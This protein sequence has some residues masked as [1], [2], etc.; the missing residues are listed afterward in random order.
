MQALHPEL[1]AQQLL[2]LVGM[3]LG[4]LQQQ[5][6]QQQQEQ[7]PQRHQGTS[8][9]DDSEEEAAAAYADGMAAAGQLPAAGDA[10][11]QGGGAAVPGAAGTPAGA[12]QGGPQAHQAV[13]EGDWEDGQA[14]AVPLSAIMPPRAQ[15]AAEPSPIVLEGAAGVAAAAPP[16]G[17]QADADES[18][19]EERHGRR[20][21]TLQ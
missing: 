10:A 18:A 14:V 16:A 19:S 6:E 9:S 12:A 8:T 7:Q 2:S 5:P 4:G 20:R 15:G 1:S 3:Q 13:G 21:C 17:S 11:A